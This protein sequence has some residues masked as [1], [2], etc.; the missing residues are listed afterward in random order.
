QVTKVGRYGLP[1]GRIVRRIGAM[2]SEMAVSEIA[3]HTH[4]IPHDFPDRVIEAAENAKPATMSGREDWRKL[5]LITIDP[6][7]AK[8]HDDAVH[9][10]ADEDPANEG[11]HVATVAIADVAYYVRPG[12]PL[13][14]EAHL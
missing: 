8:D 11:G 1:R 2:H 12:E 6:A 7:D 13:D 5:P 9:A 10:V 3:R 14:R 4:G